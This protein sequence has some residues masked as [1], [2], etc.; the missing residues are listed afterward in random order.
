M[1]LAYA[2]G[3]TI[4]GGFFLYNGIHHL[5]ETDTLAQYAAAKNVAYPEAAVKLSGGLLVGSGLSYLLGLKPRAGL[6]G[7]VLFLAVTTLAMHDFWNQKDEAQKNS[8]MIHFSKNMALLG[9]ALIIC[10]QDARIAEQ[11]SH[12]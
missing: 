11:D 6:S 7:V 4:F 3:R 9:A 8:E 5:T 12:E 1:G 10:E 2:L